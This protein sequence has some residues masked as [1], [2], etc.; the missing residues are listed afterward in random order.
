[1]V[2]LRVRTLA[3]LL[4]GVKSRTSKMPIILDPSDYQIQIERAVRKLDEMVF[5]PRS[6][7]FTDADNGALDVT[8]F[9]IDEI[10]AVYYSLEPGSSL[11]GDLDLGIGIM[12]IITSQMMPL[13]SLDSI[14]DYLI[15]KQIIN[16]L[17][18]KMMNTFDYTLLPLTSDG[19]QLLQIRNPGKLFWVEYLP[20]LNP[21]AEQWELFENE[22]SFLYE[23][24]FCYVGYANIEMQM[25]SAM[26][27]VGKE[28]ATLMTYWENK[29][30]ALLEDFQKSS[31]I[32]Y[33]G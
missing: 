10:C 3:D 12:P 30:K 1:M 16:Q 24:A 8:P 28:A 17:Q 26:L 27:G 2:S 11:L 23:L 14:A 29:I 18:R 21:S 22:Y 20:Y 32:N 25:Q 6:I 15:V 19:R 13:S 33:V 31:L 5:N 9:H 7:I 4:S